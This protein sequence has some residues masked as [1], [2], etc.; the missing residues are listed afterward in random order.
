MTLDWQEH[1]EARAEFLD[2]HERYLAIEGGTLGDE[3]AD[4]VEAAAELILE[5]PEA[6]PPLG[7]RQRE[8]V[9]RTWHL[10]KF[11]YRLVYTVRGGEILV[12]AYAHE[13]RRPGYWAHRLNH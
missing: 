9:I 6:P 11:P 10:G 12:L 8:P 1:P 3:F 5:W 4:V 7:G 13:S 2:A